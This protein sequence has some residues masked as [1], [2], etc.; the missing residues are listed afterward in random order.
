MTIVFMSLLSIVIDF[1]FGG[2]LGDRL[3][4]PLLLFGGGSIVWWEV[5]GDLRPYGI[6]QFG[7]L[8][9]LFPAM[10]FSLDV[11]GLWPAITLWTKW[12]FLWIPTT[13]VWPASTGSNIANWSVLIAAGMLVAAVVIQGQV[14]STLELYPLTDGQYLWRIMLPL[15]GPP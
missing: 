5:T 15:S 11:R 7:P 4:V 13:I 1:W 2:R 3:L 6:A 12:W 9:I 10:Y 8:L 14:S